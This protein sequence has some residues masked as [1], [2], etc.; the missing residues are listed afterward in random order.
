[1]REVS[2]FTELGGKLYAVLNW[3]VRKDENDVMVAAPLDKKQ[4]RAYVSGKRQGLSDSVIFRRIFP[5][6]KKPTEKISVDVNALTK[7]QMAALIEK[8]LAIKAPTL[9]RMGKRDL[10]RLLMAVVKS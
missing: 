8:S 9:L 3:H 2:M 6:S 4:Q 7:P 1:M 5:P 10:K